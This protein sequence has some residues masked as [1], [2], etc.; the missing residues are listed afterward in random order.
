[1]K[2]KSKFK[3][4]LAIFMVVMVIGLTLAPLMK[5][6]RAAS[7]TSASDTMTSLHGNHAAGSINAI[8]QADMVDNE[9]VIISD[10][11]NT[12]CLYFDVSGTLADA[13]GTSPACQ[14]ATEAIEVDISAD[15]TAAQVA[16]SIETQANTA[17]TTTVTAEIHTTGDNRVQL[18]ND[19]AGTAGNVAITEDV[20]DLDFIVVGMRGGNTAADHEIQFTTPTG[21]ADTTDTITVTFPTGFDLTTI[22][23]A[24]MDL[25]YGA[26]G[27]ETDATLAAAPGAGAWGATVSGQ[28][29]TFQYPSSGGTAVAAGD[30]VIIEIGTNAASGTNQIV[31]LNSVG[32]AGA[33]EGDNQILS[34]GGTFGDSGQIA[35]GLT[36]DDQVYVEGRVNQQLEFDLNENICNLGELTASTTGV[37]SVTFNASTNASSGMVVSYSGT[38]L[39]NA[40]SDT[41]TAISNTT[42]TQGTE[43]FGLNL[44]ANTTPAIGAE[45]TGTAPILA[46]AGN[47]ATAD[48]FDF[49]TGDTVANSTAG[50]NDSLATVSF[51]ANVA[52]LTEPGIYSTDLTFIAT[53]TF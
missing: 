8:P 14:A 26:T 33:D 52:S 9:S 23:F 30:V 28:I 6:A 16:T 51:M 48:T 21:A 7:I 17:A 1:M 19:A 31:N 40:A 41:I 38:T 47:Y 39:T 3:L 11:T 32:T 45:I 10:G 35:L 18:T 4:G 53:G 15:T 24:D 36:N 49:V 22:G 37:C 5:P 27:T 34:I 12:M 25:S 42:S 43:Q 20:A 13:T 44:K 29:I 2:I 50:I 46:A